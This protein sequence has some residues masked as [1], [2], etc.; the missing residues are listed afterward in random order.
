[1]KEI[2]ILMIV[3]VLC[4]SAM[5]AFLA[6]VGPIIRELHLEE[7]HA[8][9]TVAIA[10]VLW[11]L[12]S[13][14]WGRKSDIV[15]RKPILVI[16]VAG[17][18]ISYLV[19]AI[20]ID[21]AIISPP[22]VIVSLFIL[23][24]TRG[25]IGA[26][27][28]AITPVSNALIADHIEKE[29]R[30]GYIAKLAASSGIGMVIG[31][32]IGGYLANFGLSTPLYTFAILPLLGTIALY[33]ILPHEKPVTTEKTPILKVFDE[34]L[35][36][37]MFAAFITM[38]SIVT[39]QVCLGFYIIDKFG[40]DSLKAAEMTGYILACVGFSF[41]ISQILVSKSKI[42]ATKLLKYG[43]FI[44]MVGYILVFLMNSELILTLGL[45]LGAF[46]MGILFPAYQTLAVNLVKKEEQGAS[47][48]TVSAA[49]GIGM[50]IGPLASTIIY[51]LDP[52][53]PFILVSL[54]FFLLG[55]ISFKYDRKERC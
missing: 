53:A 8:G 36:I 7:W 52:T 48:G 39:A 38:F 49:Q 50:I 33:M 6:V 27:Y 42:E 13:R 10:G 35:R 20:F 43:A 15:G 24:L 12:L 55:I 40:L 23:I 2:K 25:G 17:V 31:P 32:P 34:R 19:L 41:I 45:C 5:M 18:A 16:G 30:T 44:G 22:A 14:Y 51:K 54:L 28:S 37:P 21:N 47:A 1:M 46:G 3:N 4:I 11:V 26:F 29:K 9:L